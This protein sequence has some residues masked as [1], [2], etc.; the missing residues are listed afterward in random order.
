MKRV[1]VLT[2]LLAVLLTATGCLF[3]YGAVDYIVPDPKA[4][5]N[6]VFAARTVAQLKTLAIGQSR[7]EVLERLRLEPVEGCVEWSWESREFYLRHN[8]WLRC[9]KSTMLQSPYRTALLDLDGIRHEALFYYTGGTGPEGGITDEQLTPVLIV[10]GKLVGW[11]WNHPLM[12]QLKAGLAAA[13]AAAVS[14]QMD[15]RPPPQSPR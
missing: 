11:G 14:V 5:T 12:K 4:E 7:D 3:G 8:G 9:V 13:Q 2:A 1:Y 6:M 15:D 10:G